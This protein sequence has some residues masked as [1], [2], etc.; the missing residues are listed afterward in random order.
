MIPIFITIIAL[1]LSFYIIFHNNINII[2]KFFAIILI[3]ISIYAI[4]FQKLFLPF[5]GIA[6][7]PPSL[8]PN[9]MY[10]PNTNQEIELNLNYPNGT[11]IIYWAASPSPSINS[12][13]NN[14]YDAYGTYKNSGVAII[15][16][17]IVKLKFLC[18]SKYKVPFNGNYPLNKHIHYRI[19][20]PNN[21]ILS[22]VK[23]ININC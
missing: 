5:L 1:I 7:Y 23:T 11:K 18:P 12:I 3:L 15:N 19:A 8:I 22:S 14:P 20:Y 4:F 16:N 9:E 17:N 6:A 21:P 2:I 13:Y 10:P